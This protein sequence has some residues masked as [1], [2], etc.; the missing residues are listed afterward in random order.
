MHSELLAS[1]A[2]SSQF[3]TLEDPEFAFVGRSNSGKSTLL[4]CLANNRK[5]A[6]TS[7]T[8]GRT[9]MIHF[10]R[11]QKDIVFADLPGYG[12][13]RAARKMEKQWDP[14][15]Q[16]YLA[17]PNLHGVLYLTDIRRGYDAIELDF[18][19]HVANN[20]QLFLVL[21][22]TDK[23]NQRQ[24]SQAMSSIAGE[25]ERAGI[26]GARLFPIS[27]LSNRGIGSLRDAIASCAKGSHF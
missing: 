3:P 15:V 21:T 13:S 18:M 11:W 22:K 6:R 7:A 26:E 16:S 1:A 20:T 12:Y 14:L 24:I 2:K 9:Q 8:P 5:L 4:N 17:R 19:S 23:C 10:F 27:A 25:L